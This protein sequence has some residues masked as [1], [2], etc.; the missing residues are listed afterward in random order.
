MFVCRVLESTLLE[1]RHQNQSCLS[2]QEAMAERKEDSFD[3]VTA[4]LSMPDCCWL[5]GLEAGK[6]VGSP[7][8]S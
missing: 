3:L 5:G 2:G 6:G 7:S 4:H 8:W 1:A